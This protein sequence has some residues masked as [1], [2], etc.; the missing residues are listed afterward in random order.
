MNRKERRALGRSGG[1]SGSFGIAGDAGV[2]VI[3]ARAAALHR[4]G[5]LAEAEP[6]YRRILALD[7]GDAD[8]HSRLGAVLMAQGKMMEALAPLQRAAAIKPDLFEAFASLA[9]AYLAAGQNVRAAKA[10]RR[11]VAL[12]ETVASKMLF[13]ECASAARFPKDDADLRKLLTRALSEGW[14]RPRVLDDACISLIKSNAAIAECV[15]RAVSAWPKRLHGAELFGS[16]GLATL[17]THE[18]L[19]ALLKCDP[20]ADRDLECLL[21]DIRSMMLALAVAG[22]SAG[23]GQLELFAAVAQQCFIN[24]YVYALAEQEEARALGLQAA[25]ARSLGE[26]TPVSALWLVA[27]AAYFPLHA[28]PDIDCLMARSWPPCLQPLLVQQIE[29]PALERRIAA[30][31]QVLTPIED[32]V[33]RAVREQYEE[34]PY[35]RWTKA[36]SLS[37][38]G[39]P[40]AAEILIAGCGTGLSTI[41]FARQ[42]PAA[43]ILAI[44]LSLP[45]LSFAKR[46]A[47]ELS[48]DKIQFGQ[49]DL[50]QLGGIGRTFDF[51]DASGVLHHLADPFAG[52]AILL[53]LL[54]PGGAMQVGLYSAIGRE[55][56][57]AARDFITKQGYRPTPQDIRRCRQDIF[58]ST[59]SLL[60]S[61]TRSQD[62]YT[63]S[64]CRDLLFHAHEV[65]ITLPQINA[66]LATNNL[67]FAGFNL[68]MPTL[69]KFIKRFPKREALTDLDCW[70]AF[71]IDAPGTF[72]GMYQF[73]VRKTADGSSNV[74]QAKSG[75]E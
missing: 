64:E 22:Q 49:A 36:C 46:K 4:A 26:G 30:G 70:D 41:D 34:S 63:T 3:F 48:F 60:T 23:E 42:A 72:S 61:L 1:R 17:Y 25:L 20:I 29:E 10:A 67:S 43:S 2:A 55:N 51:I 50:L 47:Q 58:S 7:P 54:R 6:L 59:D 35:P 31:I 16:S 65:R 5:A 39:P 11:A 56:I 33:S 9:Q 15:D 8:A 62:F 66:F 27:V 73:Q 24:D 28:L 40:T 53:S 18:L 14:T 19:I 71:E 74:R 32:D 37:L 13:A 21:T 69:Q 12:R 38:P 68:D 52:W 45:S 44:D 57:V 75:V